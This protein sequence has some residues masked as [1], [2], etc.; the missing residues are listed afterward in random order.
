MNIFV[1]D[2][3]QKK[4]AQMHN[5]KHIVKMIL[6]TSQLL[7]SVH[8][9]INI[10]DE[11]Y[12]ENIPYR[13][14]H[15][16]HPCSIWARDCKE[17]YMWLQKFGVELFKEYNYRYEKHHKSYDVIKWCGE[18]IPDLKS[19]GDITRFALAMPDECKV[20]DAVKSYRNYYRIHKQYWERKNKKTGSVDKIPHTWTKREKPEFM[21]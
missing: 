6:E 12:R 10:D 13:M 1:L 2:S 8:H 14:A 17:N 5:D 19:K 18:N 4:A 11:E 21:F 20:N 7:C 3:N 15:K 16:N 9:A